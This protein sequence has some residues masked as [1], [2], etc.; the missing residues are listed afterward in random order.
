MANNVDAVKWL[1]Q[2]FISAAGAAPA[3]S[4]PPNDPEGLDAFIYDSTHVGPAIFQG[5]DEWQYMQATKAGVNDG[6]QI[7]DAL[8]DYI[9]SV[10]TDVVPLVNIPDEEDDADASTR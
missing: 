1:H 8:V 10:D 4:N 7:K 2:L 3:I 5:E 6:R 9:G